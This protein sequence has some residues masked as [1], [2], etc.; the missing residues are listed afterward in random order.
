MVGW[1]PN[2]KGDVSKDRNMLVLCTQPPAKANSQPRALPSLLSQLPALLQVGEA[3]GAQAG[4]QA[5]TPVCMIRNRQA[6]LKH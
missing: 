2:I 1:G 4:G 5:W 6:D 3:K